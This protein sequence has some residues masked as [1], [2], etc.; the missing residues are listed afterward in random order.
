MVT[1]GRSKK[2][3]FKKVLNSFSYNF[4]NHFTSDST[5]IMY[6]RRVLEIKGNHNPSIQELKKIFNKRTKEQLFK[7]LCIEENLIPEP[8]DPLFEE[9]YYDVSTRVKQKRIW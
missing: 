9:I 8:K 3:F 7:F 5:R 2:L 6:G 4:S 1:V